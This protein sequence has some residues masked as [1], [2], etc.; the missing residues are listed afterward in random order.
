MR[1]DL[2]SGNFLWM[3]AMSGRENGSAIAES[4]QFDKPYNCFTFWY[5]M[6]GQGMG[7]LAVS[8]DISGKAQQLWSQTGSAI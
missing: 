4:P 8:L 2:F 3:H 7:Q 6:Y 1:T 5:H